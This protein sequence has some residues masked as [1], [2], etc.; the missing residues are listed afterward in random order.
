M[1]ERELPGMR[2]VLPKQS[3]IDQHLTA[4]N[5][6]MLASARARE[7]AWFHERRIPI[8]E[9]NTMIYLVP[10]GIDEKEFAHQ[11]G[12]V[13]L[14]LGELLT[15]LAWFEQHGLSLK[16]RTVAGTQQYVYDGKRAPKSEM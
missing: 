16:R 5:M 6:T 11:L 13:N 4:V 7:L 3:E 2:Q 9:V 8:V 10:D 1:R 14:V 12:Q 15:H